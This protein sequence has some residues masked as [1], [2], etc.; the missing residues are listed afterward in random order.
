MGSRGVR[1]K[2]DTRLDVVGKT[3]GM[4]IVRDYVPKTLKPK[5]IR[6]LVFYI[7]YSCHQCG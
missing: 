4:A 1:R 3:E 2:T 5:G 6:L 7:H